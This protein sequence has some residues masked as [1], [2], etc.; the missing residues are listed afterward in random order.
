MAAN[1]GSVAGR[2]ERRISWR[3]ILFWGVLVLFLPLA[4]VGLVA[5]PNEYESWGGGGVDCDGPAAIM[6]AAWP[7]AI[8]YG[9]AGLVFILRAFRRRSWGAGVGALLCVLLVFGLTN[10]IRAAAREAAEPSY[11]EICLD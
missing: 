9:L 7:T 5:L 8:V 3:G 6:L 4:F 10:N 2:G 11:R 1:A